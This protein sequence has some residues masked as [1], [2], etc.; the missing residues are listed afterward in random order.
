MK[1]KVLFGVTSLMFLMSSMFFASCQRSG[2]GVD[3]QD[4][5]E[6]TT[7]NTM[8]LRV[9]LPLGGPVEYE[10]LRATPMIHDSQEY[11]IASLK[12]FIVE[13]GTQKLL[14]EPIT[15]TD[16]TGG[17]AANSSSHTGM[18]EYSKEFELKQ[19]ALLGKEVDMYVVANE[20]VGAGLTAGSDLSS[21]FT[22]GAS[23]IQAA[24]SPVKL[25]TGAKDATNYQIPMT[26]KLMG[27]TLLS[28]GDYTIELERIVARV[29]VIVNNKNLTVE[30]LSMNN[31]MSASYLMP[32]SSKY[33]AAQ[34]VSGVTPFRFE[35]SSTAQVPYTYEKSFYIYENDYSQTNVLTEIKVKGVFNGVQK[36]YPALKFNDKNGAPVSIKRNH[37]YR[38]QLGNEPTGVL[39]ASVVSVE[40]WNTLSF[41]ALWS[42]FS[43][44]G[45]GVAAFDKATSTLT[46]PAGGDT[47]TFATKS[48]YKTKPNI[49]LNVAPGA[50]W[51]SAT[52]DNATGEIKIAVE[53]NTTGKAREAFVKVTHDQFDDYEY[54]IKVSQGA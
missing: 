10:G 3:R 33:N 42:A 17:Q 14:V 15:F 32:N 9:A 30:E 22:Q 38:V 21:L 39:T 52:A 27:Q 4:L 12:L 44:D 53:E 24:N 43:V 46:A 48:E 5:V 26:G 36:D 49:T 7:S 40:E 37:I 41:Y 35:V 34:T 1:Q 28:N 6:P 54:T 29:D 31:L 16:F 45:D 18:W 47:Y 8:T 23:H 50:T 11:G 25:F 51:V 20:A 2:T 19:A 13:K